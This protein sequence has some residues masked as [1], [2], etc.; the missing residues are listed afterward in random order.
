MD[1]K[2]NINTNRYKTYG[3][4]HF[5]ERILRTINLLTHNFNVDSLIFFV[6][7]VEYI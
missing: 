4:E 6:L 2:A 3:R 7:L 1:V 5:Y